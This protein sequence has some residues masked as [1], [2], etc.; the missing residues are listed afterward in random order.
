MNNLAHAGRDQ[1]VE[2]SKEREAIKGKIREI[3]KEMIG[4]VVAG[5]GGVGTLLV[6]IGASNP[7][8]L[9]IGISFILLAVLSIVLA[10]QI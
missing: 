6:I 7:F 10:R 5:L 4:E 8:V 3:K 2:E 1:Q 9:W